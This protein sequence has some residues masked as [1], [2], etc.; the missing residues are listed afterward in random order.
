MSNLTQQYA[1]IQA[2]LFLDKSNTPPKAQNLK[3]KIK[4]MFDHKIGFWCP[5]FGSEYVYNNTVE[6]RQLVEVAVRAK[7]GA[8]QQKSMEEKTKKV[9]E[10]I[11]KEL[12]GAPDTY[13]R[14]HVVIRVF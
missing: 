14:F 10:D 13:S 7:C 5:K 6:K 8:W 1:D 12:L 3:E 11:R 4:K 2:R 9:A